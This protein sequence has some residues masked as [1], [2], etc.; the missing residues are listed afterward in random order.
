M[1][2]PVARPAEPTAH[3]GAPTPPPYQQPQ[4]FPH[5]TPGGQPSYGH[6]ASGLPMGIP[7]PPS[8]TPVVPGNQPPHL[9]PYVHQQGVPPGYPPHP[10]GQPG[11]APPGYPQGFP[12]NPQQ[13]SPQSLYQFSPYGSPAP[14]PMTLT[15]QL[16]LFEA[17]EMPSQYKL[18]AARRRWFMYIVAGIVAVSVAAGATF[19]II[20]TTRATSPTT[21]SIHIES[22]PAG[23]EVVYDGN[24]LVDRTPLTITDIPIGT[25]HELRVEL[26]LH[27][28]Y[29]DNIDIPKSG[30]EVPVMAL[31]KPVTG[32]IVVNSQP[33]GAEIHINDQLRGRTPTTLN[34]IDMKSATKIE[35]RL[36]DYQPHVQ[37]L[38]WPPTGQIDLD[39]KLQR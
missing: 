8:G 5:A 32:K 36:K 29:V 27:K 38:V 6:D 34:D 37:D 15:G 9:Q 13:V 28:P 22:V 4:Q 39:I 16:R 35:I 18:G 3:V 25:R 31:L 2:V 1:P 26:A 19:L 23:A 11:Y 21:G 24:R 30:G 17:D 10:H 7:T 33:G 14:K 20:R 12:P